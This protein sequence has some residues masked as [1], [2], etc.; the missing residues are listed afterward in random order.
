VPAGIEGGFMELKG[1]GTAVAFLMAVLFAL[2]TGAAEVKPL[3][4]FSE[5]ILSLEVEHLA[6]DHALSSSLVRKAVDRLN[7]EM[8]IMSQERTHESLKLLA[9]ARETLAAAMRSSAA[10]SGYVAT[11]SGQLKAAG[12]GKFLPLARL[13][14]DIEKPYFEALD[15]FFATAADFVQY[16]HDN[17]EAIT[18]GK[19]AEN[20]RYDTLYT[21][22]LQ[23]MESFNARSVAR[24]QRIGDWANDYPSLWE[25]LPR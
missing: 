9:T 23:A 11:N 4:V 14:S 19:P 12:H 7:R 8:N 25:L 24:S 22:Y 13:D 2:P 18:T 5:K 21:A 10:L 15:H 3:E 20:R 1:T 16:C 6:S 17:L